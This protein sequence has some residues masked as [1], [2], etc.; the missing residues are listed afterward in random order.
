MH[1]TIIISH[2]E[3][4]SLKVFLISDFI[5]SEKIILSSSK[6]TLLLV[7]MLDIDC[8][9]LQKRE[10]LYLLVVSHCKEEYYPRRRQ[11]IDQA[12]QVCVSLWI[13]FYV[14]F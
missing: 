14:Y 11:F 7:A 12:L 5:L 10:M 8:G 9:P 3:H 1:D 2:V 13:Q 4:L 6:I